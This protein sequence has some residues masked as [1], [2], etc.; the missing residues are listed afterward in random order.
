MRP[1]RLDGAP[2]IGLG[3]HVADGVVDEDRVE[4]PPQAQR[5]H[6]A[7]PVLAFRIQG[8]ADREHL[9]RDVGEQQMPEPALQVRRA[10]AAPAAELQ[11]GPDRRVARLG[12]QVAVEGRLLGVVRRVVEQ[13]PPFGELA[14][15]A[16]RTSTGDRP[17]LIPSSVRGG[18]S[19]HGAH[20]TSA[21]GRAA[22]I[23]HP[24][25]LANSPYPGGIRQP[26]P[27]RQEPDQVKR[28][29][30]PECP[31]RRAGARR[32]FYSSTP[33]A[34]RTLPGRPPNAAYPELT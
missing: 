2:Q 3:R 16:H 11:Q 18:W 19:R 12:Q 20:R 8:A 13:W 23:R 26:E 29:N 15:E 1:R 5:A 33:N 14:V 24:D 7:E 34:S 21:G 32:P 27:S 28:V 6:V 17:A 9:R 4:R 31:R 25:A 10:V 30:D 22:L